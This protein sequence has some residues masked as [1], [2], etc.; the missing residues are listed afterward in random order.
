LIADP[1]GFDRS[2]MAD[3]DRRIAAFFLGHLK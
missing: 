1:P 3:V 2:Q